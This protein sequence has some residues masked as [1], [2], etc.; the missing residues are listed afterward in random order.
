MTFLIVTGM[1]GAGKSTALGCLEDSGF[2]CVD[3]MPPE[4]IPKFAELCA[5]QNTEVEKVAFGMDIRG[6]H[7]FDRFQQTLY[8]LKDSG[9]E[10]Q[11][12]FMEA[13]DPVLIKRYKETRRRHPLMEEKGGRITRVERAIQQERQILAA[14][15][16]QATYILDTTGINIWQLKDQIRQIFVDGKEFK[17]LMVHIISFGFKYGI[18][19]D[20]DLVFD[21]RFIP[22]PYYIPEMREQTGNDRTV[23]EYVMKWDAARDFLDQLTHMVEFLLPHYLKEGKNQLV[24]SIG[25]T[26]GKHRSVTIAN[27]LSR[28]LKEKGQSVYLHHREI[29]AK[30]IK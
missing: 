19:V 29:E 20:S 26:G 14:L 27:M 4:L 23:Q 7:F 25:C 5:D 30:S 24:I 17:S 6:R 1:S 22:N 28:T 15:K 16:Q 3:N 2:F 21:V 11:V 9:F 10:I 18:P 12:L 13:E 8:E